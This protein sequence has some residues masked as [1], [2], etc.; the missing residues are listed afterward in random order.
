MFVIQTLAKIEALNDEIE[1]LKA[2]EKEGQD[3]K[4]QFYNLDKKMQKVIRAFER[5][6][7]E[8]QKVIHIY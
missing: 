6:V 4:Q 3:F 5:K 7:D 8:L 2:Q 1:I